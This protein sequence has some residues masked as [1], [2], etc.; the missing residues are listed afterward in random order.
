MRCNNVFCVYWSDE[1]CSLDNIYLDIR[2][3][4]E[5]CI[6]VNIDDDC[7]E[8]RRK[9]LLEKYEKSKTVL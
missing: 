7:L 1:Q 5:N 2:G 8:T 3:C 4:C 6:Y 9:L